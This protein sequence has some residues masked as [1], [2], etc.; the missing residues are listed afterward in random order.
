MIRANESNTSDDIS[1]MLNCLECIIT[2][3]ET[4]LAMNIYQK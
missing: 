2:N 1:I 3:I 4:I